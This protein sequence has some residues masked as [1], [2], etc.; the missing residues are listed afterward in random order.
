M[1]LSMRTRRTKIYSPIKIFHSLDTSNYNPAR[2]ISL[3]NYIHIY[4]I[5]ICSRTVTSLFLF[6]FSFFALIRRDSSDAKQFC[7]KASGECEWKRK[8]YRHA[9]WLISIR[10][11]M[12]WAMSQAGVWWFYLAS[13]ALFPTYNEYLMK[14][15]S[16]LIT[17]LQYRRDEI[18]WT[19]TKID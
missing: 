3:Y 11:L 10:S 6:F 17:F 5:F 13:N 19:E 8:F 2:N 18:H 7:C 1:L 9:S 15:L 16:R 4:K 12:L 14:T